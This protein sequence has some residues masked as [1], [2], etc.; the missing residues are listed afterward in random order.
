VQPAM[1]FS[2]VVIFLRG[3]GIWN[4]LAIPILFI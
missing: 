2:S 1:T 4:V 3:F